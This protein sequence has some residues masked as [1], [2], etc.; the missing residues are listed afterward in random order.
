MSETNSMAPPMSGQFGLRRSAEEEL[1]TIRA[2]ASM[3]KKNPAK[4]LAVAVKAGIYTPD[5]KL[6]KAFGG[7]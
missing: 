5:G 4:L 7:K 6:T 3:L 2:I 1:E